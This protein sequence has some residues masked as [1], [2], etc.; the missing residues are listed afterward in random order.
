MPPKFKDN[1][2]YE[3]ANLLMQPTFIRVLDNI[4]K[5]A[6]KNNHQFTYEEK[7]EPFP[8]YLLCLNKG[9][10]LVKIDVWSICFEICFVDY[11][12]TENSDQIVEIDLNLFDETGELDWVKL[13]EKTIKTIKKIF[14][15]N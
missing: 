3:Q 8:G 2:A 10:D 1:L 6:E 12:A 5:E 7:T 11:K 9:E 15:D 4:R 13:E 14:D